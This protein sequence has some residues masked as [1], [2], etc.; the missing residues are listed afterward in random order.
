MEGSAYMGFAEAILETQLFK[1]PRPLM[2]RD[3]SRTLAARLPHPDLDGHPELESLIIESVDP[4]VPTAPRR[5]ARGRSTPACRRSR[6]RSTTRPACV[7]TACRSIPARARAAARRRS[8]RGVGAGAPPDR[9]S[10]G[11]GTLMLTLPAYA[12]TRPATLDALL[13]HL[14]EHADTSL[15]VAGG[16]DAVPNLKHRLHEPKPWSTSPGFASCTSSARARRDSTSAH[17]HARRDRR[18]R[19]HPPRGA[20]AG[21]RAG[22]WRRRRFATW[23]RSAQPVPRHAL[24]LL[25]P[26]LLLAGGAGFCSRRTAPAATWCERQAVRG[27]ALV[28]VA[29]VLI[30]LEAEVEIASPRG[31]RTLRVEDFFV[32]DGIHNNVLAKDEVVVRIHVPARSLG[33]PPATASCARAARS[34]SRCCRWR[35]RPRERRRLRG[36]AAGGERDRRQAA[37]H[38][39][40][41]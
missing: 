24:H 29:P 32:P 35:S 1:P 14:A 2:V 9:G 16:T 31:P 38:H 40:R 15:M 17:G 39:R 6:T 12:W 13:A 23:A 30:T 5:R 37:H 19:R 7:A 8:A 26:D 4:R 21:A 41:R 22:Q 28:D 33:S 34:T 36:R 10:G 18:A 3:P 11:S 27:R 25:Q 20:L